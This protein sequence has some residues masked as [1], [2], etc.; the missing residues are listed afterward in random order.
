[1]APKIGVFVPL[2]LYVVQI[3]GLL[4]L[5]TVEDN[6]ILTTETAIRNTINALFSSLLLKDVKKNPRLKEYSIVHNHL[7]SFTLQDYNNLKEIAK[8]TRIN[9]RN[10]NNETTN[11]MTTLN[12]LL[13]EDIE[14]ERK[15]LIYDINDEAVT[16]YVHQFLN[17]IESLKQEHG[18][19]DVNLQ[20]KKEVYDILKENEVSSFNDTMDASKFHK[21]DEEDVILGENYFW[22]P[23]Q[24]GR[25]VYRGERV[26]IKYFPFMASV[27]IFN[28][29]YCGGSIIK[30][31]LI[32]TA[33]SCLQ[34][35]Y[36][37]R[38]FRE[39][40]AFLSVRIGTTF[41]NGGENIAV[42]EV[43][44]HPEY[45][46][47]NLRNNIC[48][49]RLVRRI[50]LKK[51]K[52]KKINIDRTASPLSSTTDGITIIG[53]GA[54]G[55]NNLVMDPYHQQLSFAVLDIYPLQEC[56]EVYSREYVTRKNFCAGF[57]SKGGGACNRDVG[58]PGV[59]AG[60][61]TGVVSFGS[62]VCGT[63]DAPTV[64]TKLG[65]YSDWIDEIMA[66][67]VPNT[68]RRTTLLP[69]REL[70]TFEDHK[71]PPKTTFKIPPLSGTIK[72]IP[73]NEVNDL[74]MLKNSELFQE[75][76]AT[77]FANKDSMENRDMLKHHADDNKIL[78]KEHGTTAVAAIVN[79]E[80]ERTEAVPEHVQMTVQMDDE[81][82]TS[83]YDAGT[84]IGNVE[85]DD[86]ELSDV[87]E[88]PTKKPDTSMKISKDD[89]LEKDLV[90]LIDNIDLNEI[91]DNISSMENDKVMDDS[92]LLHLLGNKRP[93]DKGSNIDDTVLTLLYL[94]DSEKMP[95][96]DIDEDSLN[97]VS[98][99][100]KNKIAEQG[101]SI[102]T[103]PFEDMTYRN[104]NT[105]LLA[106]L[107][108]GIDLY[109]F[110]SD[111]INADDAK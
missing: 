29:F 64:F 45:N 8:L 92:K 104:N 30:S 56:Q 78:R 40:P 84:P 37:N 49:L 12:D 63:P 108:P 50:N 17:K 3:L 109:D 23:E 105:D 70:F 22:R 57:F 79:E 93:N 25:R 31:D 10:I 71:M 55:T 4:E 88:E 80:M 48:I 33:S 19:N 14:I 68:K 34:L 28:Q 60:R 98:N 44:F 5:P 85:P 41:Y 16:N 59:V 52:V 111:K 69:K 96:K 15:D 90:E 42:M 81:S 72:P 53:W 18:V 54:K 39:N 67:D 58:G 61:L 86:Q 62:P 106:S 87:L 38:F 24:N 75:F 76:L 6:N 13:N 89:E 32:I 7:I 101:L 99:N 1:M 83:S 82:A 91:I 46:P 110:L 77:M 102:D 21:S 2:L 27:Q 107:L 66:Q 94:S 9:K 65:Y 26:K 51:K 11:F 43:Y 73:I 35:A 74:R 20:I 100:E 103:S 95:N 36:N 97:N 47:K